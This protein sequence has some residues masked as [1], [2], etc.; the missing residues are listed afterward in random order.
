MLEEERKIGPKGQIVLP[1][2]M[3]K[4]LKMDPGSKIIVRLEE[5]QLIVKKPVFD[6]VG[7]LQ[8]IAR[9]GKSISKIDTHAAY[10][11][12]LKERAHRCST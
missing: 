11:E 8:K 4:A 7:V 3:R 5:G 10:E 1:S 9:S 6:A 12:E 2:A